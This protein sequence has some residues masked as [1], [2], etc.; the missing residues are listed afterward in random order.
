MSYSLSKRCTTLYRYSI[1]TLAMFVSWIWF[2]TSLKLTSCLKR[3]SVLAKSWK[4]QSRNQ[5]RFFKRWMIWWILTSWRSRRQIGKNCKKSKLKFD[6]LNLKFDYG[7]I[8]YIYIYSTT[9]WW[10]LCDQRTFDYLI[11]GETHCRSVASFESSEP[12]TSIS[13]GPSFSGLTFITDFADDD[14]LF[15]L[16]S[17]WKV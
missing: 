2:I 9:N 4:V 11:F 5:S 15:N 6:N 12:A 10:D 3:F 16:R 14:N 7:I 8:L 1:C 13:C 17:R